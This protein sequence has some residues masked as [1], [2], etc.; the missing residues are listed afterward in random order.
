MV[1]DRNDASSANTSRLLRCQ[2][3]WICTSQGWS[4][5]ALCARE[6]VKHFDGRVGHKAAF[7]T[8]HQAE[9]RRFCHRCSGVKIRP[10]PVAGSAAKCGASVTNRQMAKCSS[11]LQGSYCQEMPREA[12]LR[13]SKAL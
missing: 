13:L 10:M 11:N 5:S 12:A 8:I 1:A 2:E 3:P 4:A 6:L 7:I 9:D